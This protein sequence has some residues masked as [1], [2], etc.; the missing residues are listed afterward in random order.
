MLNSIREISI[1]DAKTFDSLTRLAL[2]HDSLSWHTLNVWDRHGSAR[3]FVLADE[4]IVGLSQGISTDDNY[5]AILSETTE[6]PEIMKQLYAG[7]LPTTTDVDWRKIHFSLA[8]QGVADILQGAN[9]S[10]YRIE[11]N[12][13]DSE[14]IYHAADLIDPVGKRMRRYKY[15]L[16]LFDRLHEGRAVQIDE[17]PHDTDSL[18]Q[19]IDLMSAWND[20]PIAP[21]NDKSGDEQIALEHLFEMNLTEAFHIYRVMIDEEIA[22]FGIIRHVPES[23]MLIV[24]HLKCDYRYRAIFDKSLHLILG[25]AAKSIAFDEVNLSS[26]MG[27]P[28]L[29]QHKTGLRPVRMQSI[30][31]VIPTESIDEID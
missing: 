26:D 7:N 21:G 20:G 17:L 13:D 15:N 12:R 11:E 4:V 18:R 23:A 14:Y 29:R 27:I 30:Y 9:Y 25:L 2:P 19:L 31:R 5:W 16:L 6:L 22:A 3:F 28:G 8:S 24:P 10:S 1:A